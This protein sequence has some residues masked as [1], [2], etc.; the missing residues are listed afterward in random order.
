MRDKVLK[1]WVK[2]CF[3]LPPLTE[4]NRIVAKVDELMALC[5]R[6]VDALESQLATV[7]ITAA[8]LLPAAVA[9]LTDTE[10]NHTTAEV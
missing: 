4:Q 9:D 8:N 5:D 7:R 3:S 1:T 2:G 10:E 6:L